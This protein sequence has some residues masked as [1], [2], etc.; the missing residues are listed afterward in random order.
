MKKLIIL[1]ATLLT[2]CSLLI[3]PYDANEYFLITQIRTLAETV[4][5]NN[6][7]HTSNTFELLYFD[8]AELKNYSQYLPNND[9][10]IK[11]TSDLFKIV[12]ELYNKENSSPE[13][14]KIKLNI[15]AKSAE[16]IQQV[17]GSKPR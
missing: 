2:G 10:E 6:P 8:A 17:T 15:I 11:L 16:R 4:N 1:C 9:A 7:I 12:E 14:C 3:G 5:C 13:Y